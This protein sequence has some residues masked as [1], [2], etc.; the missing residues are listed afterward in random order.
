MMTIET[1]PNL[2]LA[3]PTFAGISGVKHDRHQ[4]GNQQSYHLNKNKSDSQVAAAPR[5]S[6]GE[7]IT[8]TDQESTK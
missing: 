8:Y 1:E 2:K 6:D 3:K 5:D 7:V 4:H